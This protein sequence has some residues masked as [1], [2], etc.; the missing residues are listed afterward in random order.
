MHREILWKTTPQSKFKSENVYGVGERCAALR[1]YLLWHNES[2]NFTPHHAHPAIIISEIIN[3]PA[4]EQKSSRSH[5]SGNL[6]GAVWMRENILNWK[7]EH[8][9]VCACIIKSM[10]CIASTR[11]YYNLAGT[12]KRWRRSRQYEFMAPSSSW[13]YC[14]RVGPEFAILPRAVSCRH[15]PDTSCFRFALS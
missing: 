3:S 11:K 8:W 14:L 12:M 13:L 5:S 2:A 10:Q 4:A 9:S 1:T 7:L 15:S 6:S